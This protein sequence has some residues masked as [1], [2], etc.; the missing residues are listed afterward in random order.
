MDSFGCCLNVFLCARVCCPRALSGLLLPTHP[1]IKSLIILKPWAYII[2]VLIKVTLASCW[3]PANQELS[4]R[5]QRLPFYSIAWGT[6]PCDS[7]GSF[8][9]L[10]FSTLI[11][12]LTK[13]RLSKKEIWE[14]WILIS[15][16]TV[17]FLRVFAIF[18]FL[19]VLKRENKLKI[20]SSLFTICQFSIQC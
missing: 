6:I 8:S 14:N 18:Y 4:A 7:Q 17:G 2:R 11:T 5:E 13:Q 3:T 20:K 19:V 15:H 1:T 12:H 16:S 10:K 9:N